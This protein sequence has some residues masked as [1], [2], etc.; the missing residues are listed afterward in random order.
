MVEIIL[1]DMNHDMGFESGKP[2]VE[3]IIT[4][5]YL[6]HRNKKEWSL[7]T[8]EGIRLLTYLKIYIKDRTG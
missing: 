3:G 1:E 5:F 7:H 8:R 2:S 4:S 6:A